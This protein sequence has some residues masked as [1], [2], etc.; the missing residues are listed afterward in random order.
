MPFT[1]HPHIPIFWKLAE[2]AVAHGE[3]A[4]MIEDNTAA[5]TK[6]CVGA[7]ALVGDVDAS[8]EVMTQRMRFHTGLRFCIAHSRRCSYQHKPIPWGAPWFREFW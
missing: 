1:H 3:D 5:V 4:A 6:A 7:K 2:E 8:A